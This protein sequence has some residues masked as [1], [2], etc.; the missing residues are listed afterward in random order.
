[1]NTPSS[2]IFNGCDHATYQHTAKCWYHRYRDPCQVEGCFNQA[3]ARK[4]CAAHGGKKQQGVSHA[5]STSGV[6]VALLDSPKRN[7]RRCIVDGCSKF[8]HAKYRCVA[9]GGASLC[10]VQGCTTQSRNGGLCQRHGR[11]AQPMPPAIKLER[12]SKWVWVDPGFDVSLFDEVVAFNT[13]CIAQVEPID[14]TTLEILLTL[15]V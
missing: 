2:C 1:M 12:V 14:N 4:L 8:A 5:T 13:S 7:K 6:N 9:H 11:S 3:R 10:R 15:S